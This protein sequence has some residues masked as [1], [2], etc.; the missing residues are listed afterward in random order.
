MNSNIVELEKAKYIEMGYIDADD[1]VAFKRIYEACNIFGHNYKGFQRGGTKHPYRNDVIIWFP[2]LNSNGDW[3]NTISD[4]EEYI[5]ERPKDANQVEEH[6][7]YHLKNEI[8]NRIVFA[9]EKDI[10]GQFMY[11]FKGE[12]AID[13]QL[14]EQ[15]KYLVWKRITKKVKTYPPKD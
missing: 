14:T 7:K 8:Q 2:K 10:K 12:Y 13:R 6:M 9:Y 4:D 15:Q 11:R 1:D 5:Y 3:I